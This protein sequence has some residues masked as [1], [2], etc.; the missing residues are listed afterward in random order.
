M[1]KLARFIPR[2][3]KPFNYR[4]AE[5]RLKELQIMGFVLWVGLAAV[6]ADAWLS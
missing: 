4:D 5:L 1:L 6:L 3:A 2:T